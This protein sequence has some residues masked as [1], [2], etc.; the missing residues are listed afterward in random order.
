M[1]ANVL[2][3]LELGLSGFAFLMVLLCFRLLKSEQERKAIRPRMVRLIYAFML[4]TG[5][6]SVLVAIVGFRGLEDHE[7][8]SMHQQ[9]L[10]RCRDGLTALMTVAERPSQKV[11]ALVNAVR[12]FNASCNATLESL[13]DP[14]QK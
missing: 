9:G 1:P 13:D 11:D 4:C 2:Q 6:F 12:A 8:A 10:A 5:L 3:I 7:Q 14:L